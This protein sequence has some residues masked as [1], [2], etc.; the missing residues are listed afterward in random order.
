MVSEVESIEHAGL[1]SAVSQASDAIAITNTSGNII[2]VNPAF[3]ELTG[4][5]EADV[6]GQNPRVLSSGQHPRAF[7][8]VMWDTIRSGNVWLGQVV[9]RRK[10]G[11]LYREEMRITPVRGSMDDIVSYIAIK[12]DVTAREA[13]AKDKALLASIVECS[14]DAIV[15]GT[16]SNFILS[17]NRAAESL[18]GYTAEEAIGKPVSTFIP[19][20]VVQEHA[21]YSAQVLQ[22]SSV[23][24]YESRCLTKDG[25]TVPV[26]VTGSPVF[27]ESGNVVALSAIIRDIS[28]KRQAEEDQ[29]RLSSIVQYS[30]DVI[31]SVKMDGSIASWNRS[32]E[33]LL[34]YTTSEIL[35]KNI[36][37]LHG[38]DF[39]AV[40]R[41]IFE[42][43]AAGESSEA[44]DTLMLAK[45]G[46][47]I[48]VSLSVFPIRDAK[49]NPT[50]ASGIARDIRPRLEAQ[51]EQKK[52]EERFRRVFEDSPFGMGITDFEGS[53]LEVNPGLC[54]IFGYSKEELLRTGLLPLT[55]AEDMDASQQRLEAIQANP[56]QLLE[57]TKRFVHRDGSTIWTQIRM[58]FLRGSN[59]Q[60][61]NYVVQL[62]NVTA[63]KIAEQ[64]LLESE[65]RFRIMADGCPSAM[66]VTDAEGGVRFVNHHFRDLFKTTYE[67]LEGNAWQV[68]IHPD[69]AAGYL[70]A[71]SNAIQT[72]SSFTA[73]A[74]VQI[75]DGGWI[76]L[77]TYA[78]PR[79]SP[80]GEFLGHVGISPDITAR[81]Q[82]E[83]SLKNSEEKFANLR[84]TFTRFSGFLTQQ[85]IKFSM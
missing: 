44:F 34:G 72:R 22:G 52:A 83:E 59:R 21:H 10:D 79:F 56:N 35:G 8:Q 78:Q 2:Y 31:I 12:R 38:D 4:Y 17:W 39:V 27:D 69:D 82:S 28:G 85:P 48:D 61:A 55:F 14:D 15:S 25:R 68:V 46:T 45:D 19:P 71:L 32:A 6:L 50:G 74:R 67:Q 24:Q 11:T 16:P 54:E 65:D 49:G 41:V 13:A 77:S 47:A 84:R 36:S 9:N 29:A 20:D 5:D 3:C 37:V 40:G 7:Y 53:F 57:T 64:A 42:K 51:K 30:D 62:K 33:R 18:F 66:W 60:D 23:S 1:V 80:T 76:W 43:L 63:H 73:E 75:P 26:S 58:S 70:A 81:K